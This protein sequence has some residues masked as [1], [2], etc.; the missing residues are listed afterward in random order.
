MLDT[1]VLRDLHCAEIVFHI[2]RLGYEVVTTDIIEQA[3]ELEPLNP[4]IVKQ[5]GLK[6]LELPPGFHREIED[7][8]SKYPCPR[9]GFADLS[10]LLLA[11]QLGCP[12]V[13]RDGPLTE[14][15]RAENVGVRDTIWVIRKMVLAKC[16]TLAEAADALETINRERVRPPNPKWTTQ[17]RHWRRSKA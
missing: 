12:L 4:S 6:V 17:I 1:S 11:R 3:N 16:L 14:V 13:T 7:L 9:P 2:F 8:M 15:C 5:L 10:A